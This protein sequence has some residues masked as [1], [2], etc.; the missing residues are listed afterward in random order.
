MW[1]K[2]C[3]FF[4]LFRSGGADKTV[5]IW[6]M[7]AE[8]IL[9]Y[10]HSEQCFSSKTPTSNSTSSQIKHPPLNSDD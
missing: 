1:A 2:A 8:G 5:I 10:Q 7:K 3:G 4:F 9:K 6:T